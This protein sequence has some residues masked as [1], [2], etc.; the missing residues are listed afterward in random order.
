MSITIMKIEHKPIDYDKWDPLRSNEGISTYGFFD[1]VQNRYSDEE[2]GNSFYLPQK[3]VIQK[4]LAEVES[5]L[6]NETSEKFI[7]DYTLEI[8]MLQILLVFGDVNGF[9]CTYWWG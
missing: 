9:E 5:D 4:D 6:K 7:E 3:F 1:Y 8:K 2:H